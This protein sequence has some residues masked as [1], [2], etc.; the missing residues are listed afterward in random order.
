[1]GKSDPY[2]FNWYQRNISVARGSRVLFLG[3]PGHNAFTSSLEVHAEFRDITLG[4]WD[5]NDGLRVEKR[6]D[7]IV[8]TRCAYFSSDPDRFLT[9]CS[10]AADLVFVDWGLGDHWRFPK[11]RV[12]WRDQSEHEYADY[13]GKR[14]FLHSTVWRSDFTAHPQVQRFESLIS[15]YGYSSLES[16]VR[17]E[18]PRVL[19]LDSS[20]R[21]DF[22]TL[23]PES[24]QLYILTARSSQ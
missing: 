17:G 1:M 16:A 24:P 10:E 12:G 7:A 18:V 4:N 14:N 9:E 5:I 20:W 11:Y 22:L 21:C 13:G 19:E 15:R 6:Y 3:Q 2:V 8:C 23:W